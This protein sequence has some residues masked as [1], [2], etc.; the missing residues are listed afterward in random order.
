MNVRTLFIYSIACLAISSA[1]DLF[2]RKPIDYLLGPTGLTGTSAKNIITV[3]AVAEGSPADGLIAVGDKI[4]GVESNTF[5]GDPRRILGTLINKVEAEDGKL[6]LLL[7]DKKEVELQLEVLGA[8]AES[9]PY[10][11][12][13]T[14]LI[15]DR[16]AEFLAADIIAS[17]D[18]DNR[19]SRGSYNSKATHSALLGL[20]ATGEKK[21]IDLVTKAINSTDILKPDVDMIAALLRGEADM[22]YVGWY[23]GYDCLLLGEY[24]LLTKDASVLPALETY[25]VSLA[26]GQDAGGLWGHRMALNGRLP[27]YAQMNQ[28]SLSCFL[29]MLIAKKCGIKHPDLDKGIAKTYAYYATHVNEGGF[30]YGVHGPNTKAF[31]NNGMS[32]S[33]TMCMALADD[34]QGVRFFSR[35]SATAWDTPEQ[36]HASN[37]FNPLWTPLAAN[38]AGPQVTQEYFDHSIWFNTITRAYD[39]SFYRRNIENGKEGSQ[40]GVALLTYCLPRKSLFITGK[41]ADESLWLEGEAATEVV[42]MSQ[43][44]YKNMSSD[45]LLALFKNPY[46]PVRTSAIWAL[47]DREDDFLPKVVRMLEGR[48]PLQKIS[49]LE[50]FGYKCPPEQALPQIGSMGSILRDKSEHIKIRAKA[51]SSLAH[52]GEAAH[53]YYEDILQFIVDEE[54][55]DQFRDIDQSLGRSINILCS[56]PF[57]AGLVNDRKLY[58]KAV[59]KLIEHKRQHAR[60]EGINMLSETTI[61]D[62]PLVAEHL[63]SI[64]EDKNRTYHSYHSW[65]NTIGPA[66]KVLGNL[67]IEEGIDYATGV[68]DRKGGKWGF[69]VRMVCAALPQ[70]GANAK[71]ALAKIQADER[72][73][74][75]ENSRFGGL[76][77]K[78][79]ETIENDP[80]PER[81]IPLMEALEMGN[82]TN[83]SI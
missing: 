58:Y 67:N 6:S 73:E 51:A 26:R 64:I 81:L 79:V 70:Y 11:C 37:F 2:A 33:A 23:W 57:A 36:G 17:L 53:D 39:G 61:E 4:I 19:R 83:S 3:S 30:N 1:A 28:S 38:L 82:R 41:Y 62:F 40:T 65:H 66:I 52:H 55:G 77:K 74:G 43:N 12:S 35:M 47:R 22:G 76:W 54:P 34:R 75:I 60:A 68:L 24:Y 29:G 69:K 45:E 21:N 50:Y 46:P 32:G 13:K 42:E 5:N 78:M 71:D 16:A 8:Y 14:E 80:S 48:H 10:N 15:I 18:P 44:D 63:L 25:A 20:M 56:T 9:A 31:N 27:G 49:A 7:G 72:L 59:S